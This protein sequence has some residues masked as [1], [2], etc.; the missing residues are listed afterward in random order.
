[1]KLHPYVKVRLLPLNSVHG[2]Q[3]VK[4][5]VADIAIIASDFHELI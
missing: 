3:S 2:L 1:M 5:R 4:D